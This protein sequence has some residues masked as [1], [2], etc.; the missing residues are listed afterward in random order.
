MNL[1]PDNKSY[2]KVKDLIKTLEKHKDKK[3]AIHIWIEGVKAD[4]ILIDS[5]YI[6]GKVADGYYNLT[7]IISEEQLEEQDTKLKL[8]KD[9]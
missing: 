8:W 5:P 1:T 7:F 2:M 9:D 6:D 3:L 4:K